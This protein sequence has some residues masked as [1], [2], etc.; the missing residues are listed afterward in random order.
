ML[1][2]V[3]TV[4]ST[5]SIY[6]STEGLNRPTLNTF[7]S[8]ASSQENTSKSASS[9]QD[10]S[11]GEL[12]SS[13]EGSQPT[14]GVN[15]T[16]GPLS[17]DSAT[18]NKNATLQRRTTRDL[19]DMFERSS[20]FDHSPR[21]HSLRRGGIRVSLNA[22]VP[23]VPKAKP[24]RESFRSFLTMLGKGKKTSDQEAVS[25]FKRPLP[26]RNGNATKVTRD[27]K[28][29]FLSILGD[30]KTTISRIDPVLSPVSEQPKVAF[31]C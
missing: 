20:R 19:I 16:V 23:E 3:E 15:I 6:D 21:S 30:P 25:P 17:S 27:N 24:F 10:S 18:L 22:P 13:S 1:S 5:P 8:S 28:S 31:R 9:R 29:T 4:N 14:Q 11:A 26:E 7:I 12:F 2:R